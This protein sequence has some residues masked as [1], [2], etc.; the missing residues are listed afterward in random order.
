MQSM[1]SKLD[2]HPGLPL[3]HQPLAFLTAHPE[4]G[5]SDA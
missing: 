5:L 1:E 4:M 2:L 3:G